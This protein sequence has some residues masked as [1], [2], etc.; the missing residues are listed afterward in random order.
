MKKIQIGVMGSMADVPLALQSKQIASKLG[1]EIAKKKAVLVFGYEGDHDSFSTI[2][3]K[4]AEKKGGQTVA[5]LWGKKGADLGSLK[6]VKVETGQQRGGGREYP[7]VL[8]CDALICIGGGSGTLTEIAIAYQANIPVVVLKNSGGWSDK[9]SDKYVD[10]RKRMK[11][12]SASSASQAVEK[13]FK[14]VSK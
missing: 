13:V 10:D 4:S 11:V 5:F 3:A 2:A 1:Q 7:L 8:S 6:S 14:A 12:I 9:L